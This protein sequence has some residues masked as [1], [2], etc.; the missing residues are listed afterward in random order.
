MMNAVDEVLQHFYRWN[1][2]IY[3]LTRWVLLHGRQEAV[4]ALQL[5]P[6]AVVLEIGCG[7]GL[8]FSYLQR[9]IGPTGRIVGVDLSGPMLSQARRRRAANVVLVRADASRLPLGCRF[10]AVLMAYSL[11]MIPKWRAAIEQAYAL[12]Q[13]GGTLV[14]LDFAASEQNGGLFHKALKRYLSYFHVDTG[15]NYKGALSL[16][17]GRVEELSFPASYLRLIRYS[18]VR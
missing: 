16:Y 4:E 18:Q 6:G 7:T 15:R 11:S 5:S 9:E 13:P 17:A 14:I 3:D 8:N 2:P 1:A 12:L 10:D